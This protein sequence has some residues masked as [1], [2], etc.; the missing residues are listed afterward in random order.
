MISIE[1]LQ[2]QKIRALQQLNPQR[3]EILPRLHP[4]EKYYLQAAAQLELDHS[5]T[6]LASQNSFDDLVESFSEHLAE[7][8]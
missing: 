1:V 2:W 4:P 7:F 5:G 8:D 3:T 6:C